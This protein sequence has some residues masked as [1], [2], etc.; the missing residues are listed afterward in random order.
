MPHLIKGGVVA[1]PLLRAASLYG[2]EPATLRLLTGSGT[3]HPGR[4]DGNLAR[5]IPRLHTTLLQTE[6]GYKLQ[7]P[8]G[9]NPRPHINTLSGR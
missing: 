2:N 6:P 9:V 1:G 4:S 7:V 8:D 5:T 3:N